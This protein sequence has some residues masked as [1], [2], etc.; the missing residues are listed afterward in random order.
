M[1]Q[2]TQHP[3]VLGA[4]VRVHGGQSSLAAWQLGEQQAARCSSALSS[5]Q[6]SLERSQQTASSLELKPATNLPVQIGSAASSARV[7]YKE[8]ANCVAPAGPLKQA[9]GCSVWLSKRSLEQHGKSRAATAFITGKG[10]GC[11][12]ALRQRALPMG[13][14]GTQRPLPLTPWRAPLKSSQAG[15]GHGTC[16]MPP[17]SDICAAAGASAVAAMSTR[18]GRVR[19]NISMPCLVRPP[20]RN[21]AAHT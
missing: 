15:P 16:R 18:W 1:H 17:Q 7:F 3:G 14:Q 19:N 13:P 5:V 4:A 11:R 9:S 8:M 10:R 12:S 21:Q 6:L 2:F 20:Q